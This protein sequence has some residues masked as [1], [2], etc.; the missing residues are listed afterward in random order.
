MMKAL[1]EYLAEYGWRGLITDRFSPTRGWLAEQLRASAE[2]ISP[3]DPLAPL[4][5][6]RHKMGISAATAD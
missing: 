1:R 6:Y 5:E 4:I 2:R 3:A